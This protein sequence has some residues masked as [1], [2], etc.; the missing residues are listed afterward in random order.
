MTSSRRAPPAPP[1]M[2]VFLALRT[3]REHRLSLA[4]LLLAIAAG[5]GFQ[6]PTRGNLAGYRAEILDQQVTSGWGQVRVRPRKGERFRD[7]AEIIAAIRGVSNVAH[8]QPVLLLPGSLGRGG[9]VSVVTVIGVGEGKARPYRLSAG[10]DLAPGDEVG[11]L[12]GQRLARK[13]GASPGDEVSLQVLLAARPR[14]VLDDGGVGNCTLVVRGLMGG[15]RSDAVVVRRA[16]LARELG[17]EQAAT[18]LVVNAARPSIDGAR[19]IA[20]EIERRLPAVSAA[21]WLDDSPFLRNTEQA[22]DAMERAVDV[23]SLLAVSIPVM[24]LLYIEALQ[25][26]RQVS[27]LSAMGL[28]SG[29]VFVVFLLKALL[30]GAAGVVGGGLLGAGLL[31]YRHAVPIFASD[32]FVI[33]AAF[34]PV[35]ILRPM[36]L[37]FLV[38]VLAGAYPA[39]RAARVDP[40]AMLRRLE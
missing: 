25:R 36:L 4:L 30:I 20:R 38:T 39:W 18:L 33:R 14:L 5:V 6:V 11:V 34:D 9:S 23:M 29:Q 10:N 40:S 26:R 8:V 12:V 35:F 16:L 15:E 37:V 7:A 17:E 24:A 31:A 21:A 3:L 2:L 28:T 27:L 19:A 1:G 32:D 13:L 22:I